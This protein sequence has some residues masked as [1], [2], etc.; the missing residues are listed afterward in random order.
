[1]RRRAGG[2]WPSSL[3]ENWFAHRC[4]ELT[5]MPVVS[6]QQL[7][8]DAGEQ[9]C[10]A[11]W[12]PEAAAASVLAVGTYQLDE[13]SQQRLGKLLIY[14]LAAPDGDSSAPRQPPQLVPLSS[15]QL[16]GIF[17]LRWHPR[18]AMP[19]LAAALADGSLRLMAFGE[20]LTGSSGG[21]G[22]GGSG[23]DVAA[24]PAATVVPGGDEAVEGMAVSVDY[25][26]AAGCEGEQ[27]VASFSS[28]QLQLWQVGSRGEFRA[29]VTAALR[30]VEPYPQTQ[31]VQLLTAFA[32]VPPPIR[33][34]GACLLTVDL[35][36][37][38]MSCMPRR[39]P[40]LA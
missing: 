2:G 24:P 17:D 16:P 14:R 29:G 6:H 7:L 4:I 15:L 35:T 13:A 1:M 8:L 11:E 9:P 12:C 26:R 25:A 36:S 38:F 19:Q 32:Q 39:P 20:G 40:L 3:L 23:N 31:V 33:L 37:S 30:Q 10:S 22:G 5:T 28:G 27:L 34:L 18:S 21:G